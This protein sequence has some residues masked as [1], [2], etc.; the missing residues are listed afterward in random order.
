[1]VLYLFISVM[2]RGII[3]LMPF[4][5]LSFFIKIPNKIKHIGIF[6]IAMLISVYFTSKANTM[7]NVVLHFFLD[8]FTSYIGIFTLIG[9]GISLHNT[10][11]CNFCKKYR[12]I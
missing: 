4:F 11:F 1:M 7:Q 6:I 10:K 3:C 12:K 8:I 2:L 5:I 9:L